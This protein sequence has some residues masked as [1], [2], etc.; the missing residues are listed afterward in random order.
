MRDTERRRQREIYIYIERGRERENERER[1][2]ERERERDREIRSLNHLS[3][4]QWVRSATNASL[5][6]T[7]PLG[8]LSFKLP[9]PPCAVLLV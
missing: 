1:K 5:Q 8:F 2:G 4:Q 6:T 9:P 3:V 7:F